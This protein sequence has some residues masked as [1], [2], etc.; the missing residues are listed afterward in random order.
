MELSALEILHDCFMDKDLV[1]RVYATLAFKS[2]LNNFDY[3]KPQCE[4]YLSPFITSI[5]EL[6]GSIESSQATVFI[7]KVVS[8]I[9][10]KVRE[11]I[12]PHTQPILDKASKLWDD[13][14]RSNNSYLMAAVIKIVTTLVVALVGSAIEMESV[15][16]PM[17]LYTLSMSRLEMQNGYL[18]IEESMRMWHN[19][20]QQAPF[21][22]PQVSYLF[23][24]MEHILNDNYSDHTIYKLGMKILESYL[25]IGK[26]GFVKTH[27]LKIISSI[28]IALSHKYQNDIL[29]HTINT[30]QTLMRLFPKDFPEFLNPVLSDL[31]NILLDKNCPSSNYEKASAFSSGVVL[32]LDMF[33][34]NQEFFFLFM[35]AKQEDQPPRLYTFLELILEKLETRMVIRMEEERIV[36]MALSILMRIEDPFMYS[37]S[38]EVFELAL[39]F[40]ADLHKKSKLKTIKTIWCKRNPFNFGCPAYRSL[41]TLN[42]GQLTNTSNEISFFMQQLNETVAKYGNQWECEVKNKLRDPSLLQVLAE[43]AQTLEG[44][45]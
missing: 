17:L 8:A 31:F 37:K 30:M 29:C 28:K 12:R 7:L 45:K 33:F 1:T 20:V 34:Q 14:K 5:I 13:S 23:Q 35:M 22:T 18:V 42:K 41:D 25:V 16:A 24:H 27:G 40:C 3:K 44:S 4:K 6:I 32:F 15:Y 26:Q 19:C 36:V 38:P 11:A 10:M 39:N 43:H 2:M 21:L 9:I